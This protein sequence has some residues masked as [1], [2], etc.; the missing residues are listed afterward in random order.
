METL[1]DVVGINLFLYGNII[2]KLLH[3]GLWFIF[4]FEDERK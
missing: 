2:T 3:C 1:W 4:L